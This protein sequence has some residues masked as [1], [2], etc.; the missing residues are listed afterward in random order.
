MEGHPCK[1]VCL[2]KSQIGVL[3][4]EW[5]VDK[6]LAMDEKVLKSYQELWL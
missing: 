4:N 5:Q 6:I 2:S 1:A 3:R